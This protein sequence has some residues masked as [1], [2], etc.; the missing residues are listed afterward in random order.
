[1]NCICRYLSSVG[2]DYNIVV[3]CLIMTKLLHHAVYSLAI[4]CVKI[5]GSMRRTF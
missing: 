2:V 4:Y 5:Q 3:I 1:M